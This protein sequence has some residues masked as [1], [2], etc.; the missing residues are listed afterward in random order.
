MVFTITVSALGQR[1]ITDM[2]NIPAYIECKKASFLYGKP[3]DEPSAA[4]QA[5]ANERKTDRIVIQSC[6]VSGVVIDQLNGALRRLSNVFICFL[7]S[8]F[9]VA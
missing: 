4:Q 5:R 3:S 7:K 9:A 1:S 2:V 8:C 6:R